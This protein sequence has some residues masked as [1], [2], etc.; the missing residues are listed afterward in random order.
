DATAKQIRRSAGRDP[1]L[2]AL[3]EDLVAE[4]ARFAAP[5]SA[6]VLKSV[7]FQSANVARSRDSMG[8]SM[9]SR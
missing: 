8:R 9:R 5:M 1:E 4:E 6:P 3:V 7:H 2:R